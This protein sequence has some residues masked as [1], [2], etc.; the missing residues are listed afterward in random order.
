M[1]SDF[2]YQVETELAKAR[3]KHQGVIHTP[4]EAYGVIAEEVAEFFDE[5][6]RQQIH[7]AAML[8]E[9]IQIAAMCYRA[10]EDLGLLA[11]VEG[12]TSLCNIPFCTL[13]IGRKD[14]GHAV[15]CPN[16]EA[17]WRSLG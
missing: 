6:R 11:T 12:E 15:N 7:K 10:A 16:S 14:T 1:E 5:V 17:V 9:L 13:C 2:L 8:R 3:E 4:H